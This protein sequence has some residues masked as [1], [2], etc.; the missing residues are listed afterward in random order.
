[1]ASKKECEICREMSK[2][3]HRF[4]TVWKVVAIIS[5]LVAV[6]FI[7]L[8]FG[9]G[10]VLKETTIENE[11]EI[12]NSGDGHSVNENIGNV[13]N[14]YSVGVSAKVLIILFVVMALAG[15]GIYGYIAI[16]QSKGKKSGKNN[17]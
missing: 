16:S 3:K 5:T 13:G 8:Y 15:G 14:D 7:V 9:S 10:E 17:E 2:K 1:M 4:D 12:E 6:V 11:V